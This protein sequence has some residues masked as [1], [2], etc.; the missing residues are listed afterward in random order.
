MTT[1]GKKVTRAAPAGSRVRGASGL[2][3][4]VS[5]AVSKLPRVT[6]EAGWGSGSLAVKVRGKIFILL[7]RDELVFK[8]PETRVAELV[9][10]GARRFDP[11]RNGTAMKEWVVLPR[12]VR[13]AGA[14]A[15]EAHRFV[16]GA[17]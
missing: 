1:R 2:P 16:T 6:V 12:D 17:P 4:A 13:R 11:R 14:L 8:L 10:K 3:G 9:A 5:V 7:M 15:R